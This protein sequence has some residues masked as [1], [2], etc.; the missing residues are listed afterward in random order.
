VLVIPSGVYKWL[1][2]PVINPNPV[3]SYTPTHDST[4]T[5][6]DIIPENTFSYSAGLVKTRRSIFFTI[7]VWRESNKGLQPLP[8]RQILKRCSVRI[9]VET[10][11]ILTEAFRCFSQLLQTYSRTSPQ[12]GHY[13]FL[14]N[15]FQFA[16]YLLAYYSALQGAA[17]DSFLR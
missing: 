8:Y 11:A 1:I 12:S 16:I 7:K 15:A 4:C 9:S 2:N 17:T 5:H 13:R 6:T 10:P 3:Y 14:V